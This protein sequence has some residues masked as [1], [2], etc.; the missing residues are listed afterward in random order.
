MI[1]RD[2]IKLRDPIGSLAHPTYVVAGRNWTR[3]EETA[4]VGVR[5]RLA[6]WAVVSTSYP[7]TYSTRWR[8]VPAS[9]SFERVAS[10]A[11][12][13]RV[14][15]A[16]SAHRVAWGRGSKHKVLRWLSWLMVALILITLSV[17]YPHT[18]LFHLWVPSLV[19]FSL[20]LS[21]IKRGSIR[22]SRP[23]RIY[24][25]TMKRLRRQ[26]PS[27]RRLAI[28][29]VTPPTDL[30]A[31]AARVD[32]VKAT[33]GQLLSDV[34]YR[35][36]NSALF[37]PAVDS[38]REFTLLL[39]QWDERSSLH[40]D[41]VAELARTVELA[42]DTARSQAEALGLDHLPRTARP[43]ARRAVKSL[44]LAQEAT[45]DGER[46]AAL[47]RANQLLGSL[48]LY[49]LPDSAETSRALGETR[50]EIGA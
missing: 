36:E 47:N 39:T 23:T 30:A 13:E 8:L 22:P 26:K 24:G 45:T 16:S 1:R 6:G 25:D 5:W 9:R 20:L 15:Y 27:P 46:T 14:E 28:G 2:G 37:D 50:P 3:D 19:I 48:A 49:Y 34:V 11:L 40:P 17:S 29:E 33:Y 31:A 21:T 10:E 7:G 12:G 4:V 42:F 38:T 18:I 35:V 43:T 32:Q 44:R 41:G